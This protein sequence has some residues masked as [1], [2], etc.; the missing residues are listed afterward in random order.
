MDFLA[1]LIDESANS[2]KLVHTRF[3]KKKTHLKYAITSTRT[4]E[5]ISILESLRTEN[6]E[7][8]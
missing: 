3:Q 5:Y 4:Y 6:F 2:V 7:Y 8:Q 1:Q